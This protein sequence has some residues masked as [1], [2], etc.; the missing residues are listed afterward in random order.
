M[1]TTSKIE[2]T[3]QTWNP[4]VGCTKISAGCK[5]CYAETLAH[6]LRAMGTPGYENGF[7]LTLLP[8]RLQEP[9][10]RTKP[11]IY[12][13]NSMSDLFHEKVPDNF[14]EQVVNVMQRTPHHA[15]QLLTKRGARMARFF[16]TR[17]V[18]D[19]VW[20]GVSV[21]NRRHGVPRIDHL[22][23]IPAKIRFLSVEPLLEDVGPLDLTDIHWVIVGGESGPKA[24]PMAPEWADAV[25]EQCQAQN[26]A[27]FFKQWG[28]WGADGKRRA[29]SKNGRLLNGRTWDEMPATLAPALP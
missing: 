1:A 23:K 18:P 5:H 8:H 19:N 25:R 16:R 7:T 14:I 11:T 20:L 12:F 6:R 4:V 28:G 3:E 15:Y 9:L 27:F 26:V 17:P 2:W 24:R 29:K 21:E 22:R 10:R 13:V